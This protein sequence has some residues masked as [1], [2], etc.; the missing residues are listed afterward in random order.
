MALAIFDLDETLIDGDCATLWSERM[1]SL[2]WVDSS[3]FMRENDTLMSEYHEG[4]LAMED[5]MAFTLAPLKGRQQSDVA[6]LIERFI[7]EVVEPRIYSDARRVV[8]AHRVANDRLLVI[9]ASG[10]H[11]VRPIAGRLGIGEV[12]AIDLDT[13]NG[14]YTGH[15]RGIL[16]YRE[17]KVLR[18]EGWMRVQHEAFEGASFY[19]D[20]RN[21]LPLLQRVERPC[22]VNPD[23][24]L[25]EHAT[26]VGWPVFT[27]R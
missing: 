6:A 10:E 3:S 14:K 15:T 2:G 13:D 19:S 22:A 4:R 11:L 17:G 7:D 18:L 1:G 25:L 23:P 12:L 8:D 26:Q 21:D 5:Y 24:V 16:T 20:S 27:W 9:S